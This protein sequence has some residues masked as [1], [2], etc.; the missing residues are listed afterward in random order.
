MGSETPGNVERLN[1]TMLLPAVAMRST[2]LALS[3]ASRWHRFFDRLGKGLLVG[4]DLNDEKV[5]GIPGCFKR[6]FDSAWHR[7]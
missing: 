2:V 7:R 1:A 5:S 3:T 6:F 4:F